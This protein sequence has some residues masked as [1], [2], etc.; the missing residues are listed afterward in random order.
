MRD[1]RPGKRDFLHLPTRAIRSLP[2]AVRD[3]ARLANPDA[4]PSIAIANHD[5]GAE[6]EAAPPLDHFGDTLNVDHTFFEFFAVFTRFTRLALFA[7]ATPTL[8]SI[9]HKIS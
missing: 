8:L 1:S 4:D 7:V 3:S 6:R 2:N 9:L 5:D